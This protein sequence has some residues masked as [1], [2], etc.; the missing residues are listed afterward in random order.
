MALFILVSS[1]TVLRA[2][3]IKIKLVNGKTGLPITNKC[4]N[5][6]VGTERKEA[7]AIPLD[8]NGVARLYLTDK[9]SEVNVQNRAQNCGDFGVIHPAV[10]NSDT[11]RIVAGYVVCEPHAADYSW[12]ATMEFST[13][14]II[15]QGIVI[16]NTCGKATASPSPGEL[17]IFVRPL[18]WWEQLK[19]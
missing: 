7:M 15:Q 9:D 12:L 8:K 18:T 16:G 19:Q 11:L 17:L 3:T 2:Q 14:Q 5:T 4:V 6:W 13:K 1:G 10:K